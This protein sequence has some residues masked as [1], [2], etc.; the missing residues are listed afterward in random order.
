MFVRQAYSKRGRRRPASFT[1]GE[2]RH[3][4]MSLPPIGPYAD[5]K[6][7]AQA[8]REIANMIE[9]GGWRPS[10]I[11]WLHYLIDLGQGEA[12][13]GCLLAVLADF[14]TDQS[15]HDNALRNFGALILSLDL[16]L[17]RPSPPQQC[18]ERK[19][20]VNAELRKS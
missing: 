10:S 5:P 15:E 3:A 9:P 13:A 11:H 7:G 18:D 14:I 2:D 4:S 12:A 19:C 8:A 17:E 16:F 6:A 20:C 1:P